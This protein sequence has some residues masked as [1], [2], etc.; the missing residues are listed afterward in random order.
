MQE[1]LFRKS[2]LDRLASPEQL[3][4]LMQVTTPRGWLAALGL[5]SL[6]V[7]VLGWGILGSI[8]TTIP[9][10]G[11]FIR[12]SGIQ[13]VQGAASGQLTAIYVQPGDTIA[14]GQRIASIQTSDQVAPIEVKSDFTGRVLELRVNVGNFIQMGTPLL[15]LELSGEPL[16][17]VVYVS[18]VAGKK[19]RPG[20]TVQIAPSTVRKEEYGLMLGKVISVGEFP[21]TYQGMLR[22]LGSDELIRALPVGSASIEVV[23]EPIKADTESGYA[24]TS[25]KGPPTDLQSGTFVAA[26]IIT[27]ERRPIELIFSN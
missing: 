27:D 14:P 6:M 8:P 17:A 7:V 5:A 16:R 11:I 21:V 2:S 13:T 26:S 18:P 9:S 10:Q 3:D 20:M 1:R 15:S 23:V 24:W 19:L 22:V 25:P 12:G 4:Q